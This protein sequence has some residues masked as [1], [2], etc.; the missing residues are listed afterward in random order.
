MRMKKTLPLYTFLA[1]LTLVTSVNAQ[2][3]K[4]ELDQKTQR[5]TLIAEGKVTEQKSFWNDEHT[6]IYTSNTIEV[7]KTFKGRVS[8]STIEV[9]TQGGNVGTQL[10]EVSELLNLHK[11]QTGIFFCNEAMTNL[12][13]PSRQKLYDVYSS[14]QGFLRYNYETN[15]ASAPF[16]KYTDIENNLYNL[17][18]KQTGQARSVVNPGFS[19][20]KLVGLQ[21]T[22]VSNGVATTL[23]PTITSF[24]PTT[25]NAGA[26]NDPANNLLT[27]NGSGF[28]SS[29][30]GSA[31][32]LFKDGNNDDTT[33]SYKAAYNSGYIASW[34]D[35][36]IVVRVPGRAAT[37]KIT[38]VL[39]DGTTQV[40]STG[41]LTVFF[42]V[43]SGQYDFSSIVGH[44]S[45]VAKEIRLMN[46]NGTGGYTYHFNTDTTG[47]GIN[48]A[49]DPASAAFTRAVGTWKD[50]VGANV[51]AGKDTALQK[52][53][54]DGFN[55]IIYDNLNSGVPPMADGVLEAT[56][57]Y[58]DICYG[59]HPFTIFNAEKTGFDILVRNAKVSTG[60]VVT[61]QAGPCFPAPSTYDV[62]TIILH[63]MGHMLN[64]N[65]INDSYEF[66]GGTYSNLNPGKIMHYGIVDYADRRSPDESAYQG[67]LYAVTPQV[68]PFGGC[69]GYATQ[70]LPLETTTITNDECPTT[71]PVTATL[72]NTVV[73]FDL[74]HAT[75]NKHKDPA[76][77]QV[78]GLGTGTSVTNNAYYALKTTALNNGTLTLKIGNYA[79]S[80]AT[81]AACS[82]QGVRMALYQ[83]NACPVGQSFPAPVATATF[84]GNGT[85]ANIT[86]LSPNTT[87]LLYFDGLR[88]TKASF[89]VT[90][91]GSALPIILSD[92]TGEYIHG[93][94]NLYIDI[95]QAVNVKSIDIEKS[96]DGNNFAL[97]GQLPFTETNIIGKHTYVDAQPL[98]GKNYYR[99][100]ITDKD[101]GMQYSKIIVLQNTLNK[102][103]YMYPN[104]AKGQAYISFSGEQA[105]RYNVELYGTDGKKL[106]ANVY[107]LGTGNQT[108]SVPLGNISTGVYIVKVTNS[109]GKTILQQKLVKQ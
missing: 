17:L 98:A 18:E 95:K 79:T 100:K 87:Y 47:K 67:A 104:P 12:R 74:T 99:L 1:A 15:T 56:Y 29:P 49:S 85:L 2:L 38:V 106:S 16:A 69:N 31:A 50:L 89:N 83:V 75:S 32:V 84:I 19:V 5:S 61:F 42:A 62:E 27:I 8:S 33:P 41:V 70:M 77:T 11:G 54:N 13:S 7:Y 68:T 45:I 96:G 63:E 22:D 10:I 105:G 30:G 60:S 21:H 34:S 88:S 86:G 109:T 66:S 37:G 43:M 64:L 52:I 53:S 92:F 9:V 4:I 102:A 80:P 78:N 93:D 90:L 26:I 57:S 48:F 59:N 46:T 24:S 82:G 44:D 72:P 35:S 23:A 76:Y 20:S 25:V 108:I 103:T 73:T 3:Y 107:T 71:F 40:T 97:L 6:M 101:G 81:L 51:T 91:A 36:K 65:H 58:S 55:M 28:G 94:D 14:D 39:N